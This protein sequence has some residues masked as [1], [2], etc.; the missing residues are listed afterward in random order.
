MTAATLTLKLP[1]R[2]ASRLAESARIS[3]TTPEL[4]G[5][6]AIASAVGAV[7][8]LG[9][10]P[11]PQMEIAELDEHPGVDE[12]EPLQVYSTKKLAH[13]VREAAGI[14]NLSE[15]DI[16]SIGARMVAEKIIEDGHLHVPM[17]IVPLQPKEATP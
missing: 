3:G 9:Y 11:L 2:L 16:F 12:S 1:E 14:T 15:A 4:L 8:R 10:W 17:Q 5:L 13:L 7:E 6:M